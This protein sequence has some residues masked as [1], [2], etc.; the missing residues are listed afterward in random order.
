MEPLRKLNQLNYPEVIFTD[1]VAN[2]YGVKLT[3]IG[4]I[5]YHLGI[6]FFCSDNG[7]ICASEKKY[8]EK[9]ILCYKRYFESSP[10]QN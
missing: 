7:Y 8:T 5:Q 2:R 10:N 9:M 6:H 1:K 3:V 4:V